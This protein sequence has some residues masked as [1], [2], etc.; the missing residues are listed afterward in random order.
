MF[1]LLRLRHRVCTDPL[2]RA[3]PHAV[4]TEALLTT[5]SSLGQIRGVHSAKGNV[6]RKGTKWGKKAAG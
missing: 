3:A 2:M 4:T 1:S 5:V 6:D